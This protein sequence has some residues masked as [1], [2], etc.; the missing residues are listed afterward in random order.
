ME[1]ITGISTPLT[2]PTEQSSGVDK[3]EKD[4]ARLME[5]MISEVTRQ[6]KEA[7]QAVQDV[8]AGGGKNL[9]E[10]MIALEKADISTRYMVQVRNKVM[11]AYQEIMR[12]QV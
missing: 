10:A 12:M 11:E 6:Q 1:A 4:F 7:D 9:H 5:D 3:T 8:H 2:T